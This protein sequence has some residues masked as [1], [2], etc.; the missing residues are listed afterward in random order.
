MSAMYFF[1]DKFKD[2]KCLCIWTF[3]KVLKIIHC[4]DV[5]NSLVKRLS[6]ILGFGGLCAQST[7]CYQVGLV[8]GVLTRHDI[9]Q[10]DLYLPSL[11]LGLSNCTYFFGFGLFA[12]L[13]HQS[14]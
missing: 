10:D 14:I 11:H 8:I 2:K 4:P 1:P 3:L 6:I 13:E 7:S 12:F 5:I 9:P